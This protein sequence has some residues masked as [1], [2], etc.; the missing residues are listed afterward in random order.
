MMTLRAWNNAGERAEQAGCDLFL[1]KPCLPSDLLRHVPQLLAQSRLRRVRRS[2]I[3]ADSL[4]SQTRVPES[5]TIP[6]AV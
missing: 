3:N 2:P 1:L 6:H 5:P 4:T